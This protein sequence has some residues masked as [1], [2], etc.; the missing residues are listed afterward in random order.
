VLVTTGGLGGREPA[1]EGMAKALASA[2]KTLSATG[3]D[4]QHRRMR[5]GAP[6]P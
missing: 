2:I 6:R 4:Y 3:H 5:T 1:A